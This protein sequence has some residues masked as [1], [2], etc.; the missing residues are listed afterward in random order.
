G[1]D[2][3][4]SHGGLLRL[5]RAAGWL[6][7]KSEM[8]SMTLSSTPSLPWWEAPSCRC[9]HGG[10]ARGSRVPAHEAL[11]AL[12]RKHIVHVPGEDAFLVGLPERGIEQVGVML[13]EHIAHLGIAQQ[14]GLEGFREHV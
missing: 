14:E 5:K 1:D 11:P 7:R 6:A 12:V 2:D 4:I 3:G 10:H 13:Y 8:P 9:L